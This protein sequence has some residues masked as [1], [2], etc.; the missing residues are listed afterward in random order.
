MKVKYG[1]GKSE[2]GTGVAIELTG[3]EV[4]VAIDAY[5]VAHQVYVQGPRTISVN[6]HLCCNGYVYVDPSGFVISEGKKF[7]GRNMKKEE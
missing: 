7:D 4:A 3:S 1:K 6:G 5:L 2:F